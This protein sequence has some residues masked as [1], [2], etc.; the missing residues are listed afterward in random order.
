M[1]KDQSDI[2]FKSL[3]D[4]QDDS[5]ASAS[6]AD[7]MWANIIADVA[8]KA[9]VASRKGLW[10]KN[11][12]VV[13]AFASGLSCAAAIGVFLSM[14]AESQHQIEP[15][16][17]TEIIPPPKVEQI[18]VS[19]SPKDE[20]TNATVD[21]E[22]ELPAAQKLPAIEEKKSDVALGGEPGLY[23]LQDVKP[24]VAPVPILNEDSIIEHTEELEEE[25]EILISQEPEPAKVYVKQSVV[26]NDTM[27]KVV[28]KKRR[29]RSR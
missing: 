6:T 11:K 23:L 1:K 20:P 24:Q 5:F 13:L 19:I 21:A 25:T 7:E 3:D 15:K 2:L 18:P 12:L 8:V 4:F 26:K 17:E 10:V 14:D 28:K 22:K 9:P 29:L 27:V 16:L